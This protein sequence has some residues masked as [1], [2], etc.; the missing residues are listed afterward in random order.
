VLLNRVGERIVAAGASPMPDV[1]ER[2]RSVMDFSL[3][4]A[5]RQDVMVRL[6]L[7]NLLDSPYDVV[8]GTITREYYRSGRAVQVGLLWKP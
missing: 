1:L 8:Q 6:D 5:V 7:K 2:S 4:Q 3:R